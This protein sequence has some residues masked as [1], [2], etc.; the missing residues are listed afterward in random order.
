MKIEN[1]S[2][3]A[4]VGGGPAG[5][6]F[7]LYL[8]HY[9]RLKGIRPKITIY[10]QR[11][12]DE[13]G[14]KGCKGCA[15]ILSLSLLRNL[16]ELTLKMPD[17][18]IQSKI[19]HYAVHSPYNSISIS[20]PER[21]RQIVCVYRGGGPRE[22]LY[23]NPISFDGW[24]LRQVQER[25][26][27]VEYQTVSR[28]YVEKETG[29]EADG[30]KWEYDLVVLAAGIN[31]KPIPITGLDYV[32]P[33]TRTMAQ[34]EL[35]VGTSHV[36]SRLGNTAHVFLIPHSGF[37]FGT[38]IPKGQFINVSVLHRDGHCSSIAEFLNNDLVRSYL[39]EVYQ[40]A[41]GCQ[42]QALVNPARNYYAERFLAIGD[43]AVSRLY[44]DGLGSSSVLA[45]EA[46]HVAVYYGISRLDF[47]YHYQPIYNTMKSDNRWG[48]LLFSINDRT[49]NS[50]VFLLSQ[51]RLI[52]DEQKKATVKQPFSKAAWGMFTGNCSYQQIVNMTLSLTSIAKLA[53]ALFIETLGQLFSRRTKNNVQLKGGFG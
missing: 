53:A 17:D 38:L 4:I 48:R 26:M 37:V 22:S 50:G 9:T 23:E 46:A 33:K 47:K 51:Q 41:C 27:N 34:D 11:N 44:K 49:K 52:G 45:R 28:I 16:E 1:G 32:P 40:R 25:G 13:L 36:K 3:V 12:A 39:P 18:I 21:G 19:D 14:S 24:L 29:L 7:A 6:L 10:E 42:P 43:A 20:N 2:K 30:R 8:F 15:G 31:V 5:S 35:Y